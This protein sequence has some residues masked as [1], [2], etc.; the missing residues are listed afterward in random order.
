[1]VMAKKLPQK[2]AA[3]L[4]KPVFAHV[5]TVMPD[6]TPQVTPVW[7]DTDGEVVLFN[8]TKGRVKHRNIERDPHVAISLTDDENPYEMIEIRG[9]AELQEEGA[10]EHIDALAKKYLNEERYP[11]RQDGE[12]R[13]IVRVIPERV[14]A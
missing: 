5:A 3:L 1:M 7:V 6:G 9:T 14:A 2:A 13:V 4:R 8:T 11:F 10:D 12:E